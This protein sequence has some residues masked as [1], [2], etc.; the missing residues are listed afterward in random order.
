[1]EHSNLNVYLR[2]K[3]P[4]WLISFIT[5]FLHFLCILCSLPERFLET[6]TG[7]FSSYHCFLCYHSIVILQH[8][9]AFL[10]QFFLNIWVPKQ[11][12]AYFID[13]KIELFL[14]FSELCLSDNTIFIQRFSAG[15]CKIF[16]WLGWIKDKK[17]QML[18]YEPQ[19]K[20]NPQLL[21]QHH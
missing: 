10:R 14:G 7:I 15:Y 20:E 13:L 17:K 1:M 2:D 21:L 9:S 8:S 5:I 6:S 16:S 4:R 19:L 11:L 18:M 12:I 3:F